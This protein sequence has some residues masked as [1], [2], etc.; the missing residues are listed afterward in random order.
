MRQLISMLTVAPAFVS[1]GTASELHALPGTSEI[2]ARP[3][4]SN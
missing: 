2:D 4:S 1:L 3:R